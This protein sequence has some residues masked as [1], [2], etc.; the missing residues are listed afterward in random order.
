[1]SKIGKRCSSRSP[2][3]SCFMGGI[4]LQLTSVAG[5]IKEMTDTV[6][7]EV[8]SWRPLVDESEIHRLRKGE[9]SKERMCRQHTDEGHTKDK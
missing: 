9:I 7:S 8:F 2:R 3:Y 6:T 4:Q 1:V 5:I